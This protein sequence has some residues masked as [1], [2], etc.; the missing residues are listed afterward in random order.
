LSASAE[1]TANAFWSA[2][3]DG[4]PKVR[5]VLVPRSLSADAVLSRSPEATGLADLPLSLPLR[6][7]AKVAAYSG[8]TWTSPFSR[9]GSYSSRLPIAWVDAVYPAAVRTILYSSAS[10][11]VSLKLAAPM[12]IGP[13][14]LGGA[15]VPDEPALPQPPASPAAARRPT[16]PTATRETLFI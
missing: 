13:A 8:T 3:W 4:L 10:V 12:T 2:A 6:N 7:S 14:A 1:V 5:P 16:S 11:W 9:L 15:A